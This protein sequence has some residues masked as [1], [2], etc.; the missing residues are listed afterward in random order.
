MKKKSLFNFKF[1][2]FQHLKLSLSL[3][4]IWLEEKKLLSAFC[5]PLS[6]LHTF[7]MFPSHS[8]LYKQFKLFPFLFHMRAFPRL[9]MVSQWLSQIFVVW[10]ILLGQW[11]VLKTKLHHLFGRRSL[12]HFLYSLCSIL[13]DVSFHFFQSWILS[14]GFY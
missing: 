5:M 12:H 7:V 9:L 8:F 6:I 11:P 14:W 3:C 10:Y 4:I 13:L 1:D 2:V